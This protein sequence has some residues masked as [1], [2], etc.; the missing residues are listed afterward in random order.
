[1]G[2]SVSPLMYPVVHKVGSTE[3][4]RSVRELVSG[5]QAGGAKEA[6]ACG[7]VLCLIGIVTRVCR[8]ARSYLGYQGSGI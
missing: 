5:F 4:L 6:S 7:T 2:N 8:S 3:T 1:M